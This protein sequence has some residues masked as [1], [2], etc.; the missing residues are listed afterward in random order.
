MSIEQGG[1]LYPHTREGIWGVGPEERDET[2]QEQQGP[3]NRMPWVENLDR[4][5]EEG[6]A[7]LEDHFGEGSPYGEGSDYLLDSL[8]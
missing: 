7:T 3:M 6:T 4:A 8:G 1:D 2:V 5:R